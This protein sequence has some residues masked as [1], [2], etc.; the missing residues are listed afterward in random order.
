MDRIASERRSWLMSRVRSKDT[1][2]ELAVRKLVYGLGYRYRLH[3]AELPGRPDLVF[4]RRR[5]A[6]FVHG[7]F[8]HRHVG[9]DLATM[10]KSRVAF[11][12]EKF[13]ANIRRDK[14]Q[15]A[16]LRRLGWSVLV[17]WQCELDAEMRLARKI[18][19]FIEH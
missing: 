4:S 18:K 7:C 16:A 8:W 19:R 17:I 6:I 14:R 3:V 9:C 12:E 15:I 1:G 2:P 11:W 10:P 5:K 13:N